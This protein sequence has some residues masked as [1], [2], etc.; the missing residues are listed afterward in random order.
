MAIS[1]AKPREPQLFSSAKCVK[2][3]FAG[4]RGPLKLDKHVSRHERNGVGTHMTQKIA[5]NAKKP[6]TWRTTASPSSTGSFPIAAVLKKIAR[7][8]MAMVMRAPCHPWMTKSRLQSEIKASTCWAPMYLQV[9]RIT[10]S[11]RDIVNVNIICLRHRRHSC[12]PSKSTQPPN[13]KR[14]R[15]LQMARCEFRYP[16]WNNLSAT[17]R[18]TM[19]DRSSELTILST[20]GWSHRGHFGHRKHDHAHTAADKHREPDGTSRATIRERERS[21]HQ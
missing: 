12:L 2:V 16:V 5:M 19:P 17:S 6:K 3:S 21:H 14:K 8:T 9:V 10:V 11:T 13:R 4:A 15:L 18:R 20:A 7:H 1:V